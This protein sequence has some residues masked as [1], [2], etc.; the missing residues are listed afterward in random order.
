MSR[1]PR[2]QS[3]RELAVRWTEGPILVEAGAGTGKTDLLVRRVLHLVRSEGIDIER[4]V[5]ITFTIKAAAEL[6]S[7]IRAA[8]S[9]A[10]EKETDDQARARFREALDRIDRAPISTIPSSMR[11]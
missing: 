4:I 10:L 8:L 2:D 11:K 5:A 1:A 9:G 6:R 7:R 3:A